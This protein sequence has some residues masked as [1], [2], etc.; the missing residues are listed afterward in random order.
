LGEVESVALRIPIEAASVDS[1]IAQI[2]AMNASQIGAVASLDMTDQH[3]NF[4]SWRK[5][6]TS[7]SIKL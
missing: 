4:H 2:K 7:P 6:V 1:F 3:T 5:I